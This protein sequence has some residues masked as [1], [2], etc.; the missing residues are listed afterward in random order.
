MTRPVAGLEAELAELGQRYVTV[1]VAVASYRD[2]YRPPRAWMERTHNVCRFT[3]FE[4]GGHFAALERPA[5]LVADVCEF[6][7]RQAPHC[8]LRSGPD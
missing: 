3:R 6:F 2:I 1:P 5:E 8:A 4:R 7:L